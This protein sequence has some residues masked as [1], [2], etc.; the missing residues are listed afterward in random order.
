M[1]KYK[2][3]MK[4]VEEL[5]YYCDICFN[6]IAY[7]NIEHTLEIKIFDLENSNLLKLENLHICHLC[8]KTKYEVSVYHIKNE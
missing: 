7:E 4:E 2:K 8:S 1:K 6:K 3:I 5:I